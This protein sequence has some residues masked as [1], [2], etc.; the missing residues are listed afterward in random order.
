MPSVNKIVYGIS[1]RLGGFFLAE[2]LCKDTL[3]I[4]CFHG[5]SYSDEHLFKPGLFMRPSQ[6]QQRMEWL[7]QHRFNVLELGS[8]L[9]QLK[10]G[11]LP[12]RPVVITIDDGFR[13]TLDIAAPILRDYGYPSTLYVTS[14]YTGK[15]NPIFKLCV[16]YLGWKYGEDKVHRMFVKLL[17][18]ELQG[19]HE[20]E[21]FKQII[22]IA[23]KELNHEQHI[24]I[25]RELSEGLGFDYDELISEGR[26]NLLNSDQLRELERFGIDI[27]LHTHRHKFPE[28]A[29]AIEDEIARNRT[30]LAE[31]TP[32]D[33]THFC[34]P[35]GVWSEKAL[36]QLSK[37]GIES[38][39]TCEPGLNRRYDN[40]L[41][42]KR[43]LDR[44]ALP[45][46]DFEAEICGFKPLL[47]SIGTRFNTES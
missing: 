30:A 8:A 23:Q 20:E 15:D 9:K 4:L 36:P 39:T 42:L 13:S 47:R 38:A 12:S 16:Q 18:S 37:L 40:P 26:L 10:N 35:S 29:E 41:T 46:L 1:K 43:F 25:C 28:S 21:P 19:E 6:F 27:Q 17:P 2:K 32:K 24:N 31:V 11:G 3:P 45:L 44:D 5:F 7:K 14:Y 34:Y 33:L 22:D